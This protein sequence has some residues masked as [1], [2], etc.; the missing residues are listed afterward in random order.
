MEQLFE[1]ITEIIVEYGPKLIGAILVWLIGAR[2]IKALSNAFGKMLEKRKTDKSLKPF[3]KSLVC[4]VI[5][6]LLRKI[7]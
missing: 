4:I 1:Q 6:N 5:I 3:L 2:I 7:T